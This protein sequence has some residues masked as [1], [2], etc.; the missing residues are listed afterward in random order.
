MV[1]EQDRGPLRLT[2]LIKERVQ[3]GRLFAYTRAREQSV[4]RRLI[5]AGAT[6]ALP[7]L[8]LTRLA[9][10]QWRNG[11]F[12]QFV[13]TLPALVLLLAAWSAGEAAG[14]VTAKA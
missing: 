2:A 10:R 4:A 6:P 13:R 14:Y 1:V 11:S 9:R 12:S 5:L 7:L 8:L 3:Y